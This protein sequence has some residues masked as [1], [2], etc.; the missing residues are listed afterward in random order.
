MSF[1]KTEF[2]STVSCGLCGD[3]LSGEID[4]IIHEGS[5]ALRVIVYCEND[6]CDRFD[7]EYEKILNFSD[8]EAV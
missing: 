3:N 1:V 4:T 8:F 2:K 5:P 7:A 6:K